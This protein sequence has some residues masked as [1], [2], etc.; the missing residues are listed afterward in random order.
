MADDFDQLQPRH[1]IE[2]VQAEQPLRLR[3]RLA[4]ILQRNARG[5]G[6]EDR[7]RLHAGSSPA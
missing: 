5:V 1:R 6:R 2:E 4:Q 7:A 3:Q